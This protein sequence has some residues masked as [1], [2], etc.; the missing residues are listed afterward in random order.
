M[1]SGQTIA[2][3]IVAVALAACIYLIFASPRRVPQNPLPEGRELVENRALESAIGG[4]I[5]SQKSAGGVSDVSVYFYNLKSGQWTG[6]NEDEL[7]APGSLLK[8]PLM[9][10][11]YAVAE[12]HPEILSQQ[13]TF[14]SE[15]DL[16]EIQIPRP[17]TSLVYGRTYSVDDLIARMIENSG[18]NAY[19]ILS[20]RIDPN[21]LPEFYSSFGINWPV[22]ASD[23][24]EFVS[25]RQYANILI[26]LYDNSYLD[27]TY[28]EK[29][30]NLLE[31]AAFKD[32]LPAPL[33]S[34]TVVAHK[35]GEREIA[36]GGKIYQELHDCGIV[37][38]TAG[39]YVLCV[40][41]KGDSIS[42]LEPVIQDISKTV[43]TNPSSQN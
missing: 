28:S 6:V 8:M 17:P 30:L 1:E 31:R 15:T 3:A 2:T 33:P 16:N 9:I 22:S 20:S 23:T 24:P 19:N 38:R 5:A 13:A 35:F 21:S 25:A 29:A 42:R 43:Y 40:M 34:S 41:T 14:L 26:R 12:K 18:N 11:Y 37:Y 10:I 7:Y 39:D 27:S 4:V 36:E 32:G